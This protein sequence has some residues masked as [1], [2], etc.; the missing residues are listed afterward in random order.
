MA[1]ISSSS[2]AQQIYDLSEKYQ[3]YVSVFIMIGGLI[4]N[5]CI[6]LIL[7]GLRLFRGNQCA[8]YFIVECTVNIGLLTVIF[9]SRIL[10]YILHTDPVNLS[11]AWCKIR[12]WAT[13]VF[14]FISLITIC[15]TTFDQYLSTNYRYS[16]RQISTLKLA[17]RLIFITVCFATLHL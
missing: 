4:S 10:A 15:C 3:F 6:I 12:S 1:N 2:I 5:I 17:H 11:N 14:C 16:F 8:F 7:T 13:Q 9:S